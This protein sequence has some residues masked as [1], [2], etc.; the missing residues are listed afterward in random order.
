MK[1]IYNTN[2]YKV[3]Y[4]ILIF[5]GLITLFN[6]VYAAGILAGTS[7]KNTVEVTYFIN[8][9]TDQSKTEYA[10]SAF[11]VD[12]IINV[13]VVSLDTPARV[14]ATPAT[15]VV[16]SYQITNT[17][18]GNEAYKLEMNPLVS[19][20]EFEPNNL[21]LWIETND[22]PGLQS[23]DT[24]YINAIASSSIATD[25]EGHPLL[26]ADQSIIAY[27]EATI[28]PLLNKDDEGH[29][30]LSAVSTTPGATTKPLGGVLENVGDKGTALVN[31]VE[32]GTASAVGIYQVSP[33]QLNLH[34]TVLSVVDPFGGDTVITNAKVTYQINIDVVGDNGTIEQIVIQDPTPD[35]MNYIAGS[36]FL[37]G[38]ALSDQQDADVGD[39]N[40]SRHDAITLSLGDVSAPT[41]H[42]LTISYKIN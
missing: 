17:G 20:D 25:N 37:N 15:D 16:L 5:L 28:P 27:I 34:K 22:L 29:V 10:S 14:V 36:M 35:N 1:N 39:F 23:T 26:T 6:N 12:E 2:L 7:I 18:N 21:K 11:T 3:T 42:V 32:L 31:L 13:S 8:D 9:S 40:Q 41:S 19:G 24:P 33:V 4:F 30:A 38:T